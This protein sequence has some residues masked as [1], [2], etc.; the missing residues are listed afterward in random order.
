MSL[1]IVMNQAGAVLWVKASG[2]AV[3]DDMFQMIEA[4]AAEVERSGVRRVVV[5]QT[6]IV[7]D[8]RFTDHFAI[9]EQVAKTFGGLERAASIVRHS[10]RTGTSEKVANKQGVALQVFTLE[11]QAR[12]WIEEP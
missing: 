5:D 8:F 3:L 7:E 9:G 10:R 4:V 1:K 12:A 6:E 11:S 2:T